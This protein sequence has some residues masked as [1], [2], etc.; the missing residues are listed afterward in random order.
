[1]IRPN[2]AARGKS[3]ERAV[4]ASQQLGIVTLV[5][6][7]PGIAFGRGGS[8]R[9]TLGL[10]DFLGVIRGTG[11]AIVFD[12]KEC[13]APKGFPLAKLKPH[14]ADLIMRWGD[15]G[16]CAGVLIEATAA[17]QFFWWTWASL[18]ARWTMRAVTVSWAEMAAIGDSTHLI[19]F[20]R[21]PELQEKR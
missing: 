1:M 16:A 6:T 14:Q 20:D 8:V 4:V 12:A 19:K 11:R 21:I 2:A 15:A 10:P 5:K 9:A 18:Q 17:R 3:L 13:D 7:E